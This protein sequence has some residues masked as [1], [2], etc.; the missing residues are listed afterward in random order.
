M[1]DSCA[2]TACEKIGAIAIAK[3]AM[4]MRLDSSLK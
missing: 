4:L 2:A 1:I 3:H